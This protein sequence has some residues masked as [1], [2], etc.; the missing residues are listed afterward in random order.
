[1][2]HD[3]PRI[4]TRFWRSIIQMGKKTEAREAKENLQVRIFQWEFLRRNPDYQRDYD[5]LIQKFGPW[6]NE[7]GYWYEHNKPYMPRDYVFLVNEIYPVLKEICRKW[8]VTDPFPPHWT[9]DSHG[10]HEYAPGWRE[11]V[12]TGQT[13]E[14]AAHLWDCGPIE[15][16][17]I[18]GELPPF[19]SR[20]RSL[21][22][23]AA[24]RKRDQRQNDYRNVYLR[25]DATR[26][27]SELLRQTKK[28]IE[29]HRKKYSGIFSESSPQQKTR[30]RLGQYPL[31]LK[32]WDLRSQGK[33]FSEIARQLYPRED[34]AYSRRSLVQRVIDHYKRAKELIMG[35]YKELR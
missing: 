8:E 31:Y 11:F 20:Y 27:T 2:S 12:P 9:F 29:I 4:S 10:I 3:I 22:T 32:T 17:D 19:G 33:T 7:K 15:L 16:V 30:R 28:R 1:M 14:G 5:A 26:P 21:S 6:F 35:G 24:A 23:E 25:L 34:S 18:K 13:A